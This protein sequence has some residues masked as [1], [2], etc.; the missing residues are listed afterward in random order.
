[1]LPLAGTATI[2]AV[3]ASLALAADHNEAT[4]T[5]ADEIA[6]IDDVYTW[7][8]TDGKLAVIVTFGGPGAEDPAGPPGAFDADVLYTIHLDNDGDYVADQDVLVRFG[9][10][11][12]G[13]WGVQFEGIP[14]GS[15]TVSGAVQTTIDA[16]NGLSA[17]AGV[18]DDPFFF[19]FT[20]LGATLATGT[21]SF[22]ATRDSFAGKNVNA[23]VI[24]MDLI[25]ATASTPIVHVWATSGRK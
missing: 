11:A 25:A 9:E 5:M 24:Q 14:G 13:D 3:G 21:L 23:I 1:M 16:G 2:V 6:D 8:T 20:G 12:L 10:D 7:A 19:D 17:T 4:G 22:D 15:G 18:F